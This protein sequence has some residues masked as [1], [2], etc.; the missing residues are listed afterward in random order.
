MIWTAWHGFRPYFLLMSCLAWIPVDEVRGQIMDENGNGL[1]DVWELYYGA[2]GASPED[3]PDSDG[4]GNAEESKAGTNPFDSKSHLRLQVEMLTGHI[5]IQ[6]DSRSGVAYQLQVL[7][8]AEGPEWADLGS[9]IQGL[10]GEQW[11]A[12]SPDTLGNGFLRLAVLRNDR[13]FPVTPEVNPVAAAHDT[14]AD[15]QSDIAEFLAGTD[16]FDELSSLTIKSITWGDA[17]RLSWNSEEGKGYVVEWR[18]ATAGLW[19]AG[20]PHVF[21]TGESMSLMLRH[22]GESEQLFRLI[23]KDVD[24]DG[25]GLSDWEERRVGFEPDLAISALAGPGDLERLQAEFSSPVSL[26]ASARR[27]VAWADSGEPGSITI[28]REGSPIPVTVHYSVGG[29]AVSGVDFEPLNGSVELSFGEREVVIP[30]HPRA[31]PEA[32][33][34]PRITLTL[35]QDPAYE[36]ASASASVTIF[37]RRALS[38]RDFGAVGDGVADDTRAIQDAIEALEGSPVHNTLY[39][40]AGTYRLDTMSERSETHTSDHNL[41]ALG[42]ADL[43]GRDLLLEGEPGSVLYSTV[44][45]R[46]AHILEARATFRSLNFRGMTFEKDPR[47]LWRPRTVEPNGADGVSLIQ[48]DDRRVE[49]VDFSECGF[50]NC[51]GAIGTYGRGYDI[52]GKLSLFRMSDCRVYNPWGANTMDLPTIWGGGQLV[53]I[54][55]WVD[56]AVYM[57]NTFDGGSKVFDR[58]DLNPLGRKKDG[59][60]F[61]SPLRLEFTGNLVEDMRIESVYQLHDPFM[62]TT[63]EAM[64]LPAIGETSTVLMNNHPSTYEPGQLVAIRGPLTDGLSASVSLV[65]DSYDPETRRL[66]VRNT[67]LNEKDIGGIEFSSLKPVYLQGDNAGVARIEGNVVRANLRGTQRA[68]AGIVASAASRIRGNYVEGFTTGILVYGKSRTPLFPGGRGTLIESN[69]VVSADGSTNEGSATYGIQSWGP[70][71]IIRGNL[72]ITPVSKHIVG[73]AARGEGA[74]IL[75]NT[76]LAMK[77]VRNGYANPLRSVGIAHGNESE[78]VRKINNTSYGFDVGAGPVNAYQSIPNFVIDHRSVEDELPVAP[79]GLLAN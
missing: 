19:S 52:R 31:D 78:K 56:R 10:G 6:W 7:D 42:T 28:E 51:H 49:T 73:I 25:D 71:E 20:T 13:V 40:P 15:G 54:G 35:D 76:V 2:V 45:P 57:G 5:L 3:D 63:K 38:I 26:K 75:D 61:G 72:V 21:G 30:V 11:S 17:V 58:P 9:P 24:T 62:G 46:R 37:R 60:H 79:R 59:C 14:D 44:S 41:L 29:D 34:D 23:A 68:Q 36:V 77:V 12:V 65:V 48:V 22:L 70:E 4:V 33:T 69:L 53:N 8:P 1:S 50:V 66:T 16:P 32:E 67:G 39:F 74:R 18:D 47:V 27:P 43:A 64:T 55:S